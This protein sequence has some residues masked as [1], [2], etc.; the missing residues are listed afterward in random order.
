MGDADSVRPVWPNEA[1][2]MMA[3]VIAAIFHVTLLHMLN[4]LLGMTETIIESD[5]NAKKATY[6]F[7]L[8]G[9]GYFDVTDRS[10]IHT[11][12]AKA[13]LD[14]R[15][16]DPAQ[17]KGP[18]GQ[19]SGGDKPKLGQRFVELRRFDD[20]RGQRRVAIGQ[21]WQHLVRALG[22]QS[23]RD[24]EASKAQYSTPLRMQYSAVRS[25]K[26]GFFGFLQ[27]FAEQLTT[28]GPVR[29]AL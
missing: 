16:V 17:D 18:A 22:A 19:T 2:V 4:E 21:P 13:A 20:A 27:R 3:S 5:R 12:Q 29:N 10:C 25:Q 24:G 8:I 15:A 9:S 14:M 7:R 23:L 26:S 1:R 11:M 28:H 6:S